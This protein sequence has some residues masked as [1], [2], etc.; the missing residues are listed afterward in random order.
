MQKRIVFLFLILIGIIFT[1]DSLLALKKKQTDLNVLLIT[2]DTIRPDRLSCYS[3]KYLQTPRIDALAE[4]GAVFDRAFAHNPLT[5]PSHVNIL[6][7]TTPLYHG[8]HENS[9]SIVAED[10]LTL[11]EY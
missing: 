2:I 6:L 8:V 7:G 1:D 4:K 9:F 10:F 11:A 5:L 3:T